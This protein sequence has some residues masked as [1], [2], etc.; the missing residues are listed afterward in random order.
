[1]HNSRRSGKEKLTYVPELTK[2]EKSNRKQTKGKSKEKA[3]AVEPIKMANNENN[4]NNNNRVVNAQAD[5]RVL[6]DTSML[7]LGGTQ[8]SITRPSINS[9][10]FEIKPSLIQMI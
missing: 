8:R 10:N 7:G 5:N 6:L 3:Q 4:N 2:L 1:M 9:N